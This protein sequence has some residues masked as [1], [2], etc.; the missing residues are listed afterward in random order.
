MVNIF[1]LLQKIFLTVLIVSSL[2]LLSI[3]DVRAITLDFE[4]FPLIGQI[5]DDE[6]APLVTI[7][8]EN[9]SSGPG[10]A[11]V[12]NSGDY[13]GG[14]SDL[15]SPF[16]PAESKK[17]ILD[18]ATPGNILI[19]H[20][21]QEDCGLLFCVDPDDEGSRP[22]GIFT[23]EFDTPVHLG[24]IDFFD[25]EEAENGMT[26]DNKILLY[27]NGGL[28]IPVNFWTPHT[29]NNR[30][31]RVDFSTDDVTRVEIHLGGSG[32]IDNIAFAVPEPSSL[33]LLG[34][35]LMGAAILRRKFSA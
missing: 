15:A 9:L 5:I 10:L 33:L 7:S 31:D 27:G 6:Y 3:G 19:I 32:A 23:I 34:S 20:E 16:L 21:H 13:T 24:S 25:I 18:S 30:W 35:G 22:A 12:F 11:V 2:V 4:G 29:G 26:D 17:D 28:L 8:A 1:T 14:D